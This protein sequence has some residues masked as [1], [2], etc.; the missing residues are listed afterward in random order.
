MYTVSTNQIADILHLTLK[1]HTQKVLYILYTLVKDLQFVYV[2]ACFYN[3]LSAPLI[4]VSFSNY[5]HDTITEIQFSVLP[6]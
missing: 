6:V 4:N 2:I 5:H 1:L 3:L